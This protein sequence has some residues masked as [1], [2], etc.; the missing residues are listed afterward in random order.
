MKLGLFLSIACFFAA[1]MLT[2]STASAFASGQLCLGLMRLGL[3]IFSVFVGYID[4]KTW[5][6]GR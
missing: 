4:L 6:E 3:M 5:K 1:G 2:L